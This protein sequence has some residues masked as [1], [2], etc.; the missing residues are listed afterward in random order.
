MT[1]NLRAKIPKS[2][3]LCSVCMG[4][5]RFAS[6]KNNLTID[7]CDYCGQTATVKVESN[8]ESHGM[9]IRSLKPIPYPVSLPKTETVPKTNF[10]MTWKGISVIGGIVVLALL[11]FG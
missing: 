1:Q 3:K 6:N 9:I 2:R 10:W 5:A 7:T 4:F 11:L 8:N